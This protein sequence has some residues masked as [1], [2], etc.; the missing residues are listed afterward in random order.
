LLTPVSEGAYGDG[1]TGLARVGPLGE[2][3]GVSKLVEVHVLD[4]VTR[5]ESAV[6]ALRWE[7]TGPGGRLFPALDADIWLTPAG[8]RSA[9]LS[10]AGVYRPP[11]GALGAGLD[12]AVFHRVA[13]ATVRSLLARVADVLARP[14]EPTSAVQRTDM[15][16]LPRAPGS[17][18]NALARLP[19][20]RRIRLAEIEHDVPDIPDRQVQ[21]A[22]GVLDLPGSRM[23]AHQPECHFESEPRGE[24]PS[25]HEVGHAPGDAVAVLHQ[26]QHRVRPVACPPGRGIAR[27]PYARLVWFRYRSV[28]ERHG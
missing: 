6:L 2:V 11:L 19:S 12:R 22:D 9:R 8:E 7:A 5:G 17:T 1:L 27:R 3:Q 15:T 23:V 28:A 18:R 26:E 20:G 14:Q 21:L 24:Q 10:L 4:M 16:G 13:D 25:H